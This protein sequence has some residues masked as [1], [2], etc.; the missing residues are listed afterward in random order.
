MAAAMTIFLDR[1]GVINRNRPNYIKHW[2]EFQFLPGARGALAALTRA[3]HRLFVITNQACVGKGVAASA[4]I[5]E[6]HQRMVAE[7][8]RGGG[9]IEAVFWCPHRPDAGCGC[10]KPAPGLVLRAWEEY[11]ADLSNAI[12]VGDS[13]SDVQTATAVGIPAILVLSGLGLRTAHQLAAAGPPPCRLA[14][15][16]AH[17]ARLVLDDRY[18]MP[19][20]GTMFE[21]AVRSA[22][23]VETFAGHWGKDGTGPPQ[24][25]N[26]IAV[27]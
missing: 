6:I 20:Q 14:L 23:A 19:R 13:A 21:R 16:L 27:R 9:R 3:G 5:E 11:G 4:N 15:N 18:V 1:D 17:A 24:S 7:I 2:D 12:F 10:R 25:G 8:A 26:R 22:L